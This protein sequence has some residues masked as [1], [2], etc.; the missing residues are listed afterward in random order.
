MVIFK[1][2]VNQV[3]KVEESVHTT[4]IRQLKF[5]SKGPLYG[6]KRQSSFMMDDIIF[7]CK[8]RSMMRSFQNSGVL[9]KANTTCYSSWRDNNPILGDIVYY[10]VF[11]DV[12][13]LQYFENF[14]VVLFNCVQYNVFSRGNRVKIYEYGLTC[15]KNTSFLETNEPFIL[16]SQGRQDFYLKDNID[17]RDYSSVC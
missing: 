16:S 2:L 13:Q 10:S 7:H 11:M 3:G 6:V 4:K 9:C 5:L 12:L 1:R 8:N 17:P 15:V 14:Q